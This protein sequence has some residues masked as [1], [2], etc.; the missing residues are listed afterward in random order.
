M[1]QRYLLEAHWKF[2]LPVLTLPLMGKEPKGLAALT[3]LGGALESV[4][5]AV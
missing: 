2:G 1:Q 5:G 3:E 4:D